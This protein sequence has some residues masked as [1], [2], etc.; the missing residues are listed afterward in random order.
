MFT[1]AVDGAGLY[2][3]SPNPLAALAVIDPVW[4]VVRSLIVILNP[5]EVSPM[6][7]V[8]VSP[9]WK[10]RSLVRFGVNVA[11][12]ES[13]GLAGACETPFLVMNAKFTYSRPVT[14]AQVGFSCVPAFMFCDR[15]SML[16][17]AH[18][19]F[20]E[21]LLPAGQGAQPGG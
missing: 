6:A 14:A 13:T 3:T 8:S 15:L 1:H 21:Q 19:S 4:P 2:W 11:S 10:S 20:A 12:V 18:Q 17:A 16:S 9:L 7:T 5:F